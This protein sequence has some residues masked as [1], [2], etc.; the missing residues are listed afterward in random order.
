MWCRWAHKNAAFEGAL[1]M[2]VFV[3]A[4]S[5]YLMFCRS[6]G[7]GYQQFLLWKSNLLLWLVVSRCHVSWLPA[8]DRM[9]VVV[10][11]TSSSA[12]LPSTWMNEGKREHCDRK[13]A[14]ILSRTIGVVWA[15][16]PEQ[17]DAN[18][19]HDPTAPR[20]RLFRLF[21]LPRHVGSKHQVAIYF[22]R[23]AHAQLPQFSR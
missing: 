11:S 8:Y 10:A 14:S 2:C 23:H 5:Q 4:V 22:L 18:D 13:K 3:C 7:F 9:S 12:A 6:R 1:V 21:G 19:R 20:I 17:Q 16:T 15:R